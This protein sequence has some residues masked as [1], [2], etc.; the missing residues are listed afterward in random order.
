M[1][2][3]FAL[4]HLSADARRFY[5][6]A[7]DSSYRRAEIRDDDDRADAIALAEAGYG[8][9]YLTDNG[10]SFTATAYLDA[11]SV[12]YRDIA[13]EETDLNYAA[14]TYIEVEVLRRPTDSHGALLA[15]LSGATF[16][17]STRQSALWP[18]FTAQVNHGTARDADHSPSILAALD[19]DRPVIESVSGTAT[20][21]LGTL[22][23]AKMWPTG[24]DIT[25]LDTNDGTP[26]EA[27]A[28]CT[29]GAACQRDPHAYGPYLPEERDDLAAYLGRTVR[30]TITPLSLV[31]DN[32][33]HVTDHAIIFGD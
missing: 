6:R 22:A 7:L 2:P 33:L 3:K 8:R 5:G 13:A 10:G 17:N 31:Q 14:S 11:F 20:T 30:L 12:A 23:D 28:M 21:L 32:G 4:A 16:S 29:W 1:I 25:L 27:P 9:A 15:A 26:I 18:T 19:V 24:T